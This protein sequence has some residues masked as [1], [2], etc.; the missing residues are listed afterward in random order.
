MRVTS[1]VYMRIVCASET[2]SMASKMD[3]FIQIISLWA[4]VMANIRSKHY[5]TKYWVRR[6]FTWEKKKKTKR[7]MMS[8]KNL[9][10]LLTVTSCTLSCTKTT[11][12]T[13]N[14]NITS[15]DNADS[16]NVETFIQV[17]LTVRSNQCWFV[18]ICEWV[19]MCAYSMVSLYNTVLESVHSLDTK[20]IQ[21]HWVY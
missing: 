3:I 6:T 1:K 7:K 9:I 13:W 16:S 8:R 10:K 21:I 5:S 18:Y 20:C 19:W 11:I 4:K 2:H 14:S 15:I 17:K 12:P